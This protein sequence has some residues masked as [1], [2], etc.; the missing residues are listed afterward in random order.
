MQLCPY[1]E[2]GELHSF[3][4][5]ENITHGG[6]TLRVANAQFSRCDHCGE[7]MATPE[8]LKANQSLFADAKRRADGLMTSEEIR[9]WR[10][11]LRWSQAEAVALLG[12]GANAFSKYERGEVVQSRQMDL[13]MRVIAL[14]PEA[15]SVLNRIVSGDLRN[16]LEVVRS[17][18]SFEF[19]AEEVDW[20]P[21]R[22]METTRPAIYRWMGSSVKPA[23][24]EFGWS[25]PHLAMAL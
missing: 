23:N 2:S 12:G 25:E 24:D 1:C 8:Q 4:D 18:G 7:E 9:A 5:T 11:A 15:R 17:S 13:L 20:S 22:T 16:S 10:K 19:E 21:V 14:S 3:T 6:K